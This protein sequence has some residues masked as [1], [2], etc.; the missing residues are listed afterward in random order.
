[1]KRE[2]AAELTKDSARE[3]HFLRETWYCGIINQK[4]EKAAKDGQYEVRIRFSARSFPARHQH[5][6]ISLYE[7]QGYG[8]RFLPNYAQI[9]PTQWTMILTWGKPKEGLKTL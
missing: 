2:D 9:Q 6:F 3:K 4:I 1:M 7:G 5:R 8:V